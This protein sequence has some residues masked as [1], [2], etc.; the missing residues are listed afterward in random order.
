M[1]PTG[2]TWATVHRHGA[3]AAHAHAAGKP[4]G[5]RG[6]DVALHPSYNVEYGLIVTLR[7]AVHLIAAVRLAAPQRYCDFSHCRYL[8]Q[9]RTRCT[10]LLPNP[11][12]SQ[13]GSSGWVSPLASVARQAN[14]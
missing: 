6:I 12:A 13:G 3:A 14:S 5:K 8:T 11:P 1:R 10:A 4:V 9:T 2:P 7:H